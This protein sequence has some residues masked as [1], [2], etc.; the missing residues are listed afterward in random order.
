MSCDSCAMGSS[1]TAPAIRPV[2]EEDRPHIYKALRGLWRY[3]EQYQWTNEVSFEKACSAIDAYI[4]QGRAYVVGGYLVM[5]DVVTPWYSHDKV[6]QEWLVLKLYKQ[7]A[8]KDI[9]E[10]LLEI[11]RRQGCRSVISGDSSPV[12]IMSRAYEEAGWAPLTKSY[13][14]EVIHG[15]H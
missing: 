12:N 14:K 3:A 8:V 4:E 1:L 6:L 13:T 11:A 10:A 5:T 15:V 9:P 2:V 7:G